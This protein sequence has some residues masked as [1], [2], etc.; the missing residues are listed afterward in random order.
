MLIF[1]H[2][3]T[4]DYAE[5]FF[6]EVVLISIEM[7]EPRILQILRNFSENVKNRLFWVFFAERY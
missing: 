6:G 2:F 4:K 7:S 3:L 5:N 1:E